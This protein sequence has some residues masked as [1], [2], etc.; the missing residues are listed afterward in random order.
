[1]IESF[2]HKGLEKFFVK[3]KM[4]GIRPDHAKKLRLILGRLAASEKASDMAL[5]V[6]DFHPLK[7]DMAGYYAVSVSG[8]WR[9]RV[10]I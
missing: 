6:M 2:R 7:G 10:S 8:N 4:S 5:P 9:G 1:M 3:G